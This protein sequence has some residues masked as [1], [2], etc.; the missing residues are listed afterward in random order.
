[1]ELLRTVANF[2]FGMECLGCGTSSERLDPWLCPSCASELVRESCLPKFP[3]EDAF[4]LFPMRPLTRRLVHALKYRNIPGLASYLVRHS[5]AVKRGE[6]AQELLLL[7]QPLY[8]VSV[9]LQRARF[10]ERGYNQAELLA[11]ALATATGGKVCR[12]L[13]RKT[14]IVSQTKLSKEEREMNVAGAFVSNFPRKMPTR[15]SVVVVDDV[16]TT[17]ATTSACLAAFGPDFPLPLK[18]CTL[19]YDEPATA[20][21]DFAADCRADWDAMRRIRN[22]EV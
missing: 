22:A 2:V 13:K 11:A 21:A 14:F 20:V 4:C 15:G 9:P 3:N 5:S 17:G 16:F 10:R 8:F 7:A 12:W 19:I 18:V 6:V 1:M